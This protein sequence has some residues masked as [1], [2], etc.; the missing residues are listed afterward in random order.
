[1][2]S[3][4]SYAKSAPLSFVYGSV[5]GCV[6]SLGMISDCF[7]SLVGVKQGES[8][9][10]LLFILLLNDLSTELGCYVPGVTRRLRKPTSW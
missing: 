7:E 4:I 6:K 1:M 2:E 3:G 8:L 5:K 9:S 10:P